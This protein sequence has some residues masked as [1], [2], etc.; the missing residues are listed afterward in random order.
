M[1][2]IVVNA[3]DNKRLALLIEKQLRGFKPSYQMKRDNCD[4]IN[5]ELYECLQY[6]GITPRRIY[7]LYKVNTYKGWLDED[8]FTEEELDE[9]AGKYGGTYREDLEK[10][11]EE[12]PKER[13]KEYYYIPHVFLVFKNLILDAASD[14]FNG[15]GTHSKYR[16]FYSNYSPVIKEMD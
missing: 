6:R 1:N 7:G 5:D 13:Q 8:D 4:N 2:N 15:L 10:Y 11:V 14:M 12:L 9:I 16:Y 3:D